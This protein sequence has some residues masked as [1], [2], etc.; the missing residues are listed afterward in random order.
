MI[1]SGAGEILSWTFL[2]FSILIWSFVPLPMFISISKRNSSKHISFYFLYFLLLGDYFS[3]LHGFVYN[4]IRTSY[5]GGIIHLLFDFFVLG[6]W[7]Y[8]RVFILEESTDLEY[9]HT[10]NDFDSEYPWIKPMY[11][12]EKWISL[13]TI[14]LLILVT[15]FPFFVDMTGSMLFFHLSFVCYITGIV[16]QYY[17]NSKTQHSC[18]MFIYT[19]ILIIVSQFLYLISILMLSIDLPTEKKWLFL[20][21][22]IPILLYFFTFSFLIFLIVKRHT[23][24]SRQLVH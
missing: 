15:L 13:S 20:L 7:A 22:Q 1:K 11:I 18:Y 3:T 23:V 24:I 2:T 12:T 14:I 9:Y 21:H 4:D 6:Y 17:K 8:H 5:Y 10:E 19:F 16:L